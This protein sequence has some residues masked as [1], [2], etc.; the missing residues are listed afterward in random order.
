VRRARG[1]SAT[2][3]TVL[4]AVTGTARNPAELGRSG[5]WWL[6]R[7]GPKWPVEIRKESRRVGEWLEGGSESFGVH[8]FRREARAVGSLP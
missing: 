8:R 1:S 5:L 2:Q 3:K 4:E 7:P 6:A